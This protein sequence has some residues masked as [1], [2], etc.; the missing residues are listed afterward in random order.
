MRPL[1][2]APQP[3]RTAFSSSKISG[4]LFLYSSGTIFSYLLPFTNSGFSCY[5]VYFTAQAS[6]LSK[7][8]SHG[9]V[10]AHFSTFPIRQAPWRQDLFSHCCLSFACWNACHTIRL[11]LSHEPRWNTALLTGPPLRKRKQNLTQ[12]LAP[13]STSP[14]SYLINFQDVMKLQSSLYYWVLV[15]GMVFF[16][17]KVFYN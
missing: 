7:H 4:F 12:T 2:F 16:F 10:N 17:G 1:F 14:S 8:F 11:D 6:I 9:V 15:C 5:T 13:N 3:N